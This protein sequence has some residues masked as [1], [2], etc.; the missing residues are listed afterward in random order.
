VGFGAGLSWEAQA[1]R[2]SRQLATTSCSLM[3]LPQYEGVQ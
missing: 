2:R 1:G 3:E